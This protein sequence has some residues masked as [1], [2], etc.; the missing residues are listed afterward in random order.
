MGE[1]LK[2]ENPEAWGAYIDVVDMLSAAGM[3]SDETE[4]EATRNKLKVVRRHQKNWRS[5]DLSRFFESVDQRHKPRAQ[6][7]KPYQRLPSK[8]DREPKDY[9]AVRGLPQNF[10]RATWYWSLH[11]VDRKGLNAKEEMT[12]PDLA[13]CVQF[14]FARPDFI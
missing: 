7:N 10:Y 3:S 8:G 2:A 4:T 9:K 6:G 5:P 12:L 13:A 1:D 11:Q 14:P